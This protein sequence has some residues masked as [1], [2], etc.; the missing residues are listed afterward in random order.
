MAKVKSSDMQE[1]AVSVAEQVKIN[2]RQTLEIAEQLVRTAVE[3]GRPLNF[4]DLDYLSAEVGYDRVKINEEIRRITRVVT[5][6]NQAGTSEEREKLDQV[7][8]D[9]KAELADRKPDIEQQIQQLQTELAK[10]EK[11][12][13]SSERRQFEVNQALENLTKLVGP[14]VAAQY[15]FKKVNLKSTLG[16]AI[17][18]LEIDLNAAKIMTKLDTNSQTAL[19]A[20]RLQRHDF[21]EQGDD[22]GM[23]HYRIRPEWA[24]ERQQ[25]LEQI[26][27]MESQ[28]AEMQERFDSEL[29][30]MEADLRVYWR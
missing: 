29:A 4:E 14:L 3:E 2:R 12:A 27:E 5:L 21:V 15:N 11:A 7:V 1:L 13:D 30:A 8:A 24:A 16:K 20:L 6:Q 25:M 28:L 19:Q 9:A 17:G 18:E 10:L 22:R 23:I 26:P